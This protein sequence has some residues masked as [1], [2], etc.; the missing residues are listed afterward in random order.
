MHIND[1]SVMLAVNQT[2]TAAGWP[3]SFYNSSLYVGPFLFSQYTRDDIL[4]TTNN[5]LPVVFS[6]PRGLGVGLGCNFGTSSGD[7]GNGGYGNPLYEGQDVNAPPLRVINLID[8]TPSPSTNVPTTYTLKYVSMTVDGYSA[9]LR[10]LAG[11]TSITTN[12]G[13][14]WP[15]LLGTSS[16]VKVPNNTV[17]APVYALYDLGWEMSIFNCFGGSI[18][19]VSNIYLYNGPYLPGDELSIGETTY[20]LIPTWAGYANNIALA[21]P[22]E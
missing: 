3:T 18:S 2:V 7:F 1:T 4:N 10:P 22:K 12:Y 19:Q 6:A 17:T 13:L 11:A 5:I 20:I 9:A 15:A 8:N 16:V 14:T 21:I